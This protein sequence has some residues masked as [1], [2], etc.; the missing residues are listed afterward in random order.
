MTTQLEM[1]HISSPAKAET[2]PV[3]AMLQLLF[4]KHIMYSISAVARLGVADYMSSAPRSV[5]EIAAKTGAHAGSL[6]RI[7]RMLAS[8]GV[9]EEFPGKE[10]SLTAMGEVLKTSCPNSL[11]YLAIAWGDEWSCRGFENFTYC[12]QT[13]KDGVTKAYGKHIFDH[14]PEV[15]EQA[16]TFHHAMINM[17]LIAGE[18]ALKAY[19]FSGINRLADVGGGHGMLLAS[20]LKSYPQMQGVLYDLPEVIAGAEAK[21][22]FSGIEHQVDYESGSFFEHVPENCDAYILKHI[23]HDW[24]DESCRKILSFIREQ[25]PPEGRVL[26]LEMIVPDSPEPAPAKMLDIEML[27][28]TSGGKERTVAEFRE[29]L[30][31]AGLYLH[32]VV[33]TE[34]AMCLLEARAYPA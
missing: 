31:S 7:M 23:I 29:L 28:L 32:R 15:P 1:P 30:L 17:S 25:L 13:G 18:A 11:R 5:S 27:V 21:G 33:S 22:H 24:D 12:L 20:I 4:G 9:F 8:V 6:Y 10:F 26:L 34:S 2:S 3:A 19:D 16:E 14:F